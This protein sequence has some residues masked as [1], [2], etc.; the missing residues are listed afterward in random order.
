MHVLFG[1]NVPYNDAHI[2]C[3]QTVLVS[4]RVSSLSVIA[5]GSDL[6]DLSDMTRTT[7][8]TPPQKVFR[9]GFRGVNMVGLA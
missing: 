6:M 2:R 9:C 4:S 1:L 3:A 8:K 7:L 5:F